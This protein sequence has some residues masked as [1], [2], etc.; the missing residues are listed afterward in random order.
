MSAFPQ[1]IAHRAWKLILAAAVFAAWIAASPV[2]LPAQVPKVANLRPG[3]VAGEV[4]NAKGT[5]VPGAAVLWQIADGG[6]P[7]V[8]RSDAQGHFRVGPLRSGLY[9]VRASKGDA[10]SQ[11][12][13]NLLIKPGGDTKI[14]L[15]LASK[16]AP[17]N[18]SAP[19]ST[20]QTGY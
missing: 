3:A 13:R 5:P 15:H 2:S 16:P 11:W 6:R 10:S 1:R 20:M 8:V 4:V 12:S 17:K 9:D 19:S 14:T 18:V 7:H